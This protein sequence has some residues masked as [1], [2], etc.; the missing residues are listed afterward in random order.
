MGHIKEGLGKG[1]CECGLPGSVDSLAASSGSLND[2]E[3]KLVIKYL[4][5]T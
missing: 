2:T 1:P 4:F 3:A 5:G